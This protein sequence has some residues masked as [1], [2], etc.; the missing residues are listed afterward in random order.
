M[1][2]GG[3]T[4]L[5]NEIGTTENRLHMFAYYGTL[6]W[7]VFAIFVAAS[8]ILATLPFLIPRENLPHSLATS[9]FLFNETF[10]GLF[11]IVGFGFLRRNRNLAH[12]WIHWPNEDYLR[13]PQAWID[14]IERNSQ[15]H[16]P[17]PGPS[18]I[19]GRHYLIFG[20]VLSLSYILGSAVF[21]LFL[22]P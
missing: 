4:E 22:N 20:A 11:L 12:M 8:T 19:T 17:P 6:Q 13:S 18:R 2:I 5:A 10:A 21:L 15:R 7:Q 14:W 9:Y 1:R 16:H 3:R